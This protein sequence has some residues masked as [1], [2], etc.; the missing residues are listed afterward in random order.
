MAK[1]N[2][3]QGIMGR[4]DIPLAQRMLMQKRETIEK[5]AGTAGIYREGRAY[6]L[7]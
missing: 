2:K 4:T 1:R 7:R 6:V 3:S 5:T